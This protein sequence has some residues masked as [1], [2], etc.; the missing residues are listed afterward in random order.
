MPGSARPGLGNNLAPAPVTGP[1]I[2]LAQQRARH[3]PGGEIGADKD[4]KAD[5]QHQ[6]GKPAEPDQRSRGQLGRIAGLHIEGHRAVARAR[7]ADFR[8]HLIGDRGFI[9]ADHAGIAAGKADRIG[10]RGELLEL[11]L[12]DHF[13]MADGDAGF[14]GDVF[15]R[16]PF[17]L[18]PGTQGRACALGNIGHFGGPKPCVLLDAFIA[19]IIVV[20]FLHDPCPRVSIPAPDVP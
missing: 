7:I 19:R 5:H 2:A 11:A 18:A 10:A 17:G 15:E 20:F 12:L 9:E 4:D 16:E 3:R 8:A 6:R 1:A 13:K 14:S